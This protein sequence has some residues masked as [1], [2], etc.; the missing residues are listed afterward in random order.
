ML[1]GCT[2]D[3]MPIVSASGAKS[4]SRREASVNQVLVC[5]GAG[6]A[7]SSHGV[8]QIGIEN[9]RTNQ[10]YN[11]SANWLNAAWTSISHGRTCWMEAKHCGLR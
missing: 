10:G 9:A 5:S 4:G 7:I 6:E 3:E 8:S 11:G 2:R 1:R